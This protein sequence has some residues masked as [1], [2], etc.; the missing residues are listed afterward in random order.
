MLRPTAAALLLASLSLSP[1]S[2]QAADTHVESSS[3]SAVIEAL[4]AT[5]DQFYVDRAVGSAYRQALRRFLETGQA[6]GL[7]GEGLAKALTTFLQ[8]S[9]ADAHLAVYAPGSGIFGKEDES[10]EPPLPENAYE[11][12][13]WVVPGVAYIRPFAFFGRPGDIKRMQNFVDAHADAKALILDL[14][15][16]AGGEVAEIDVLAADLFDKPTDLAVMHT[17][18]AGWDRFEPAADTPQLSVAK[19]DINYV[20]QVHR[21]VPRK[22]G[23]RMAKIPV[24]VLTSKRT[25]SAGEHLALVL[26]RTGRAVLIGETTYGAGN[27]G[28]EVEL[29]GGFKLFVPYGETIDPDTRKGWEGTGVSPTVQV[30]AKQA[31][32]VALQRLGVSSLAETCPNVGEAGGAGK[33]APSR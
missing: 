27:Y 24:Y 7:S 20:E 16:H 2:L 30:E 10:G 28:E 29:A 23:A 32:N 22:G 1:A 13:G 14:R 8:Q 31:L 17:R 3:A 12:S 4:G 6:D 21:A 19:R 11:A 5:L 9:H 33:L 15:H 26:K 25:A 18:T